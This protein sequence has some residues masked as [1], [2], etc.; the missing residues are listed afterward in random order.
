MCEHSVWCAGHRCGRSVWPHPT[1][2]G[3]VN[4]SAFVSQLV[5]GWR[6]RRVHAISTL[7]RYRRDRP[8]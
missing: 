5:L 4:C 6:A 8:H 3:Y 7:G 1:D 2:R